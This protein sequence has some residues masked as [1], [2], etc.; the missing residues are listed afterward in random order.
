MPMTIGCIVEG[1]G[2]VEAVPI[3]IRRIAARI[4]PA[5]PVT[6]PR[7][8]RLPRTKLKNPH[9]LT[10]AITLARLRITDAGG[11]IVLMDADEECPVE[12]VPELLKTAITAAGPIPLGIVLA[13]EEY[14]AWFLAS[15]ESIA[16]KRGLPE[17]LTPPPDPEA[18]VGA[19]GWLDRQMPPTR[20]YSETLDQPKLTAIFDLDA[21]LRAPSFDKFYREVERLLSSST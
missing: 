17:N 1:D 19:K 9:E 11:I 21:A 16:G 15:A 4:D 10:R 5:L 7:P 20:K 2:E 8:I 14:E 12:L 6:I 13:K 18:I 3:L